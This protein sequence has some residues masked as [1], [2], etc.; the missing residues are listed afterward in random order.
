M[1]VRGHVEGNELFLTMDSGRSETTRHRTLNEPIILLLNLY[2]SLASNGFTPGVTYRVRIFDPTTLSDGDATIAVGDTE[3]VRWGG[4]RKRPSSCTLRKKGTGTGLAVTSCEVAPAALLLSAVPTVSFAG[5]V[6][7]FW[8]G[9][10]GHHRCAVG[11]R[12]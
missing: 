6:S 11:A 12:G 2:Y 9:G 8:H 3:V 4:H 1:T 7:S 10:D 5:E